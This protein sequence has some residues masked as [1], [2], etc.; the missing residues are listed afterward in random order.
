MSSD[1]VVFSVGNISIRS[2][3]DE[4]SLNIRKKTRKKEVTLTL[5]KKQKNK[6][7]EPYTIFDSQKNNHFRFVS[8]SRLKKKE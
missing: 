1:H 2:M 6:S 5:K 3:F 7:Y 4:K 8:A